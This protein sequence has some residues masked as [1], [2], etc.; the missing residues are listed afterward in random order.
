MITGASHDLKNNQIKFII[1]L[2]RN[3]AFKYLC[4]NYGKI[5]SVLNTGE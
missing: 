4:K 3:S 2:G 5:E 1:I